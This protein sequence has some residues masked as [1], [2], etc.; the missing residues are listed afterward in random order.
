LFLIKEKKEKKEKRIEK[1]KKLPS[2]EVCVEWRFTARHL[3]K[4][5]RRFATMGS[6]RGPFVSPCSLLF[7]NNSLM[8]QPRK[9][10]GF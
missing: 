9:K 8:D 3:A 6:P 2:S 5:S 4:A 7:G 1:E 10:G